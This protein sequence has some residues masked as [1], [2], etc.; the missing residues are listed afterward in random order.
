MNRVIRSVWML[1]AVLALASVAGAEERRPNVLLLVSDD[2]AWTDYGFVGHEVIATPHLDRLSQQSLVYT[3]GYVPASLCRPSLMTMVT[4]RY[5]H[6]HG[7]TGNDPPMGTP[8]EALLKFVRNTPTLP[9]LLSDAGYR[10]F[11]SGKWWEGSYRDGGFTHG[12]T[13]GDPQ[14]RGRHGDEGLKIGR[15]GVEPVKE[16]IAASKDQPWFVW[17]APMMPHQPHNPPEALLEKYRGRV[18]SLHVARYYAMCEWWD[19]TCGELLAY[20]DEQKLADNTLVVYVTDNGWIQ[21]PDKN[22]FDPRSK[23]SPYDGGLRTPIMFRWP[24]KIRPEVRTAP[25]SS[26]ALARTILEA[27]GVKPAPDMHGPSLMGPA[28]ALPDAVFGQIFEHDIQAIDDP[29][30]G[31]L[32]SWTRVGDWKLIE[33]A[34]GRTKELYRLADDPHE[35]KNLAAEHPQKLAELA[36]RLKAW[37]EE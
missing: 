30:R 19:Q 6:E 34:D 31:L 28:D 10:T 25:A 4:G 27:C 37:R 20:L 36:A 17:Y 5:P 32:F 15:E 21:Q 18:D 22:T 26:V 13:H 16:F 35:T 11:Q 33:S 3:H 7:V 29:A 8:R 1:L 12:M 14:R 9:R 2:H 23:R 24:G